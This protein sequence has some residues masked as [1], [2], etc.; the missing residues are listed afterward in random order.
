MKHRL[1]IDEIGNPDLGSSKDPNHRY[2]SLTGIVI[3]LKTVDEV[4]H[5]QLEALKRKYFQYH[6][7]DPVILHRKEILNK[8][9]DLLRF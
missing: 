1:Y 2:L 6:A 3:N 9:K 4:V 8:K 5:P 7:D